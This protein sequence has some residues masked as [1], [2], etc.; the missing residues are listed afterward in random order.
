M[1]GAVMWCGNSGPRKVLDCVNPGVRSW[2]RWATTEEVNALHAAGVLPPDVA[3]SEVLVYACA[4]HAVAAGLAE[5]VGEGDGKVTG[6][7]GTDLA[8]V[9]HDASCMQPDRAGGC[10]VCAGVA[11]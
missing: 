1:G 4:D 9:I 10:T 2:R 11:G 7:V 3:E 5:E 6:L 8:T